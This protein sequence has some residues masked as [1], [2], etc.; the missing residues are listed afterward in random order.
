[1][2]DWYV[3]WHS[4]EIY[5]SPAVLSVY[6]VPWWAYGVE[7]FAEWVDTHI[8]RHHWC[9]PWEWTFHIPTYSFKSD[10]DGYLKHSLGAAISSSFQWVVSTAYRYKTIHM[11]VDLT[12]EWLEQNGQDDPLRDEEEDE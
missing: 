2:R 3:G 4:R 12:D 11:S 7:R 10:E 8:F 6:E 5:G 9:A 1:M